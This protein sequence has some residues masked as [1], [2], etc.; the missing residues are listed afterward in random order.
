[1]ASGMALELAYMPRNLHT[2]TK[3]IFWSMWR[4]WLHTKVCTRLGQQASV[5][6]MEML[7]GLALEQGWQVALGLAHK[8][9]NLRSLSM[10]ISLSTR[11]DLLNTKVC[12]R[13]EGWRLVQ[14]LERELAL[15]WEL[16]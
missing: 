15:E 2:L 6:A 7:L 16:G 13:L 14:A 9:C 8:P 3:Y 4:N 5:Q 12:T 1:M 10:C 11:W